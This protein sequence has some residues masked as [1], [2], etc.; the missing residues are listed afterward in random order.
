MALLPIIT[1]IFGGWDLGIHADLILQG[2]LFTQ[3]TRYWT[4]Y[5]SDYLRNKLF[6]LGLCIATTAKSAHAM[7]LVWIQNVEYFGDVEKAGGI[8][9]NPSLGGMN[10]LLMTFIT[11]YVQ[12]FFLHRLWMLSKKIYYVSCLAVLFVF[13][14]ISA[15]AEI[16]YS[17]EGTLA[18]PGKPG[19]P[20]ITNSHSIWI[21]IQTMTVVAGDKQSRYAL[22]EMAGIVHRLIRLT[23]QSAAPA[24]LCTAL[25]TFCGFNLYMRWRLD[26][27]LLL[28]IICNMMTPKLYAISAMWT[29]NSRQ[30][31]LSQMSTDVHFGSGE[32]G[33]P[34]SLGHGL[35]R[36]TMQLRKGEM[37]GASPVQIEAE[38]LGSAE[39]TGKLRFGQP[40]AACLEDANG[41]K[42]SG[43]HDSTSSSCNQQ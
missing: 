33:K 37:G 27:L 10:I 12:S 8:F 29:L 43:N 3:F 23:F 18:D 15:I 13:S 19:L 6:V 9:T 39:R 16:S 41:P 35:T 14:G 22:P 40:R 36:T 21:P 28:L 32:A 2:L 31:L 26:A 20:F 30:D 4:Q 24:A 7:T 17:Y 38:T 34:S 25:S 1:F 5:P 42:S 11:L